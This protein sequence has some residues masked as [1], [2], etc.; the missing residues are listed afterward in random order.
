MSAKNNKRKKSVKAGRGILIAAIAVLL[1]VL[2]G[3]L[4]LWWGLYNTDEEPTVPTAAPT[5]APTE[6]PPAAT[7]PEAT[8]APMVEKLEFVDI[9]LGYGLAITDVDKY[10]GVYMEDGSNEF[11]SGVLM[12]VV[13]NTSEDDIQYAEIS[14]GLAEGDAKF[15]LSTL[16]AGESIVLLEQT[17]L[18]WSNSEEYAHATMENVVVFS[19][20]MHLQE[21]ALKVQ[22]LDGMLNITNISGKDITG[23]IVIYYK[24]SAADLLYGGITYRVRLEGGIAADE[25]RQLTAGHMSASGSRLM[26]ITIG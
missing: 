19:E 14:L 11:V 16:P 26:F 20:S 10:N 21:N 24:N 8:K 5:A 2:A 13:A 15:N 12:I 22:M 18:P 17:R 7:E 23:D 6:P 1:L 25:I 3:M 9:N 4:L